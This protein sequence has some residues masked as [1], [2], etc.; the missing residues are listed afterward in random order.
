[1]SA[2][3]SIP[4]LS[5]LWTPS[6]F[7]KVVFCQNTGNVCTWLLTA[8]QEVNAKPAEYILGTVVQG[9]ERLPRKMWETQ[10][11]GG[12]GVLELG[13]T[14]RSSQ[15]RV[16][17]AEQGMG[18]APAATPASDPREPTCSTGA[19]HGARHSKGLSGTVTLETPAS[20]PLRPAGQHT[21]T[22]RR[23]TSRHV[24]WDLGP[25]PSWAT[26]PQIAFRWGHKVSSPGSENDT[27][28]TAQR[29]GAL[30]PLP[31]AGTGSLAGPD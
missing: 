1:M 3:L 29:G 14:W 19:E 21:R 7:F 27:T 10:Q 28:R 11:A 4:K 2:G 25:A 26:H 9:Q 18:S 5:K 31:S 30:G 13:G 17:A 24:H 22:P 15:A 20:V 8:W 12:E 6:R 23:E 16:S